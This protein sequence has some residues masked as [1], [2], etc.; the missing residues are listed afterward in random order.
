MPRNLH[1]ADSSA[2]RPPPERDEAPAQGQ[3]R[4]RLQ[5][6]RGH[7]CGH[8]QRRGRPG[9]LREGAAEEAGGP[10]AGAC[11]DLDAPLRAR[12]RTALEQCGVG[13]RLAGLRR[14][15][16][17]GHGHRAAGGRDG[18][19]A[20]GPGSGRLKRR[21][22]AP[23]A[24]RELRC[25]GLPRRGRVGGRSR[26]VGHRRLHS[27][28]RLHLLPHGHVGR[29]R[30]QKPGQRLAARRGR[31]P[32]RG[33]AQQRGQAPAVRCGLPR[34]LCLLALLPPVQLIVQ[35]AVPLHHI[36]QFQVCLRPA[37]AQDVGAAISVGAGVRRLV[38]EEALRTHE[39]LPGKGALPACLS[40]LRVLP[41]RRRREAALVP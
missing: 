19:G 30:A 20:R 34:R 36:A 29:R 17:A 27:A 5:R 18:G 13:E 28:G 24:R 21:L 6:C 8:G 3:Y 4:R 26:P 40:G 14:H 38:V 2:C 39:A 23:G 41:P 37:V 32:A 11:Q 35:H 10:W 25:G 9:L 16:A 22:Q 15:L 33:L 7:P 1:P 31:L 12:H